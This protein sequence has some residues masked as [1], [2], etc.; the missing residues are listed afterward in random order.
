VNRLNRMLFALI[1]PTLPAY[2]IVVP[3]AT[4]PTQYFKQKDKSMLALHVCLSTQV[5]HHC[6]VSMPRIL[7]ILLKNSRL[8]NH[9]PFGVQFVF[10]MQ[11]EG[12]T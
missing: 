8:S 11:L 9:N 1:A 7:H 5:K 3:H 12:V 6:F 2:P 4:F 10:K